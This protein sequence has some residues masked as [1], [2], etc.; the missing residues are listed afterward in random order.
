MISSERESRFGILTSQGSAKAV[1]RSEEN[2]RTIVLSDGVL[3]AIS[4]APAARVG[5]IGRMLTGGGLIRNSERKS[6]PSDM[7]FLEARK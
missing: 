3:D 5:T 7:I 2:D 4:L 6:R 1:W